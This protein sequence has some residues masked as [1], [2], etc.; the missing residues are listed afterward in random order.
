MTKDGAEAQ[1]QDDLHDALQDLLRNKANAVQSLVSTVQDSDL[2]RLKHA[3][4]CIEGWMEYADIYRLA[5]TIVPPYAPAFPQQRVNLSLIRWLARNLDE[6]VV[7]LEDQDFST[8]TKENILGLDMRLVEETESLVRE[9]A[10]LQASERYSQQDLRDLTE[11]IDLIRGRVAN[12]REAVHQRILRTDRL[13]ASV[14]AEEDARKAKESAAE[15]QQAA[16]IT[17]DAALSS[18][19][20]AL[21]KEE[22]DAANNFRKVTVIMAFLGAAATALFVMGPSVGLGW[23]DIPAGD[24]VH[25]IQRAVFVA[26]VFGLAGYFARQAHQHRSMANWASALSVQLKT[27]DAYVRAI[28]SAD[29]KDELR[30]TFGARV[31][32]DHPAMKG[33]PNVTPSAA[34]MD[35]AVGW[36]AK[37]TGGGK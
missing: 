35:T 11:R 24:Y 10:A 21:A 7:R 13:W 16:G 4:G 31:F 20:A 1:E 14:A 18:F 23:L 28:E 33:E 36:A 15:A 17:G 19:Y 34:A 8:N 22:K 37:L 26:G 29:V 30:K 6:L 27:F 5:P 25:L 3:L 12:L 9:M 2:V 32:G